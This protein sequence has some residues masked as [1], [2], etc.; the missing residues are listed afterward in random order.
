MDRV[1]IRFIGSTLLAIAMSVLL[2][3]VVW[4]SSTA[5]Q[6]SPSAETA[7]STTT[8]SD[9]SDVDEDA[10]I[11]DF[12]DTSSDDSATEIS[13]LRKQVAALTSQVEDLS[14][15]VL[16]MKDDVEE[17]ESLS[18]KTFTRIDTVQSLA[19]EASKDAG[20][21]ITATD[22][23][24]ERVVVVELRS[25]QLNDEGVYT[26]SVTPDQLSRKLTP[27][28]LRGDWPL[29]RVQ[30]DLD[31]KYL[32][33]PFSGNCSTRFGYYSVLVTDAFRRL[34]CARIPE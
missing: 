27:T 2:V 33:M 17:I 31:A 22:A 11:D 9:D 1:S 7:S 14:A 3:G 25:S 28:D 10:P 20:R 30:G 32:L 19:E 18:K 4:A 15:L 21:A 23:L 13:D 8:P 16:S 6:P 29:D 24:G 34:A 5:Q 26:G 12:E